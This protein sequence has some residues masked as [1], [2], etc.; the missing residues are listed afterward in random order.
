[1]KAALPLLAAL[2]MLSAGA[3][4]AAD[5]DRGAALYASRCDRCHDESVHRRDP[6]RRAGSFEQIRAYVWRWDR[7]LGT[8]WT[9]TDIDAVSQYLNETYYHYPCPP[10]VC[11]AIASARQPLPAPSR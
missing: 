5:P 11:K 8:A 7:Q 6:S 1:M 4:P 3:A 10:E 2:A 9:G